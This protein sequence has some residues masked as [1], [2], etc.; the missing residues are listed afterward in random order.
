MVEPGGNVF[1]S[2]KFVVFAVF[3]L[4]LYGVC[5]YYYSDWKYISDSDI[6]RGLYGADRHH[7]PC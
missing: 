6:E 7:L 5:S 4:C 3:A 2:L 1:G